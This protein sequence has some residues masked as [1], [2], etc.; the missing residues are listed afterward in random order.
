MT[1]THCD[2]CGKV[3]GIND[4]DCKQIETIWTVITIDICSECYESLAFDMQKLVES[5]K[6]GEQNG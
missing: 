6:K 3:L 4:Y 5:Y 1:K 2:N